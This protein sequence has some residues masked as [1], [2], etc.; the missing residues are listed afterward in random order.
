MKHELA[1]SHASQSH[2]EM[3]W[4]ISASRTD[5]IVDEHAGVWPRRLYATPNFMTGIPSLRALS[6][7]LSRMPVSGK[8]MTPIG[9]VSS[10]ASLRLEGAALACLVQSGLNAICGTLRL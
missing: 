7:R 1:C 6:A 10:M 5:A 3:P 8:W 4:P 9:S 2:H